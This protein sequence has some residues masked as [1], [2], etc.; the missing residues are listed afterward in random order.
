MIAEGTYLA[1]AVAPVILGTSTKKG[2]PFLDLYFEVTQGESKGQ[3]VRWTP[4][5][6]ENTAERTLD[7]LYTCGW[8]G[9][10]LSEF[11][12]R[13]LHGLDA[14]EVQIVIGIE[15]YKNETG[16]EKRAPRVQWVNRAQGYLSEAAEMSPDAAKAF[17]AR[18]RGLAAQVRKKGDS[19]KSK[20]NAESAAPTEE[21]AG[22]E[23][24]F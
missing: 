21:S 16:E 10:D 4:Y 1:R 14:N 2:T 11:S 20:A 13:G 9:D 8:T 23:F 24:P 15:S 12:D 17:G 7:S 6:T 22:D 3:R 18:M 5:I 19:K